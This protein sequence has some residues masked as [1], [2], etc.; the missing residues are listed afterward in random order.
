VLHV[1]DLIETGAEQI[2]VPRFVLLFRSHSVPQ[3]QGLEGI[4]KRPEIEIK[5]ARKRPTKPRF[6]ANA[7][8]STQRKHVKNQRRQGSSRGTKNEALIHTVFAGIQ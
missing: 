8:T 5:I 2:V 3:K 4:T 7:V 6:L 1:D